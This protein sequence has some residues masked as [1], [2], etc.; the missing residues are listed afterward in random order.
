MMTKSQWLV[1]QVMQYG[2]A[3]PYLPTTRRLQIAHN[4]WNEMGFDYP[5]KQRLLN[6]RIPYP[7]HSL[8][9]AQL[10]GFG[11]TYEYYLK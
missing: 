11:C 7:R 6:G 2:K 5:A 10:F 8:L 1:D 9:V 4:Y 3:R